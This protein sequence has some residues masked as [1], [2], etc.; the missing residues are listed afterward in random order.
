MTFF[1]LDRSLIHGFMAP[2][3]GFMSPVL[4]KPSDL[5]TLRCI[6]ACG[7]PF[8]QLDSMMFC[9]GKVYVPVLGGEN[10]VVS[11]QG[12]SGRKHDNGDAEDEILHFVTSLRK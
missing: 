12:C 1:A 4:A 11:G 3:T 7:T 5:S 8:F 10:D 2:F 6:M 9:M